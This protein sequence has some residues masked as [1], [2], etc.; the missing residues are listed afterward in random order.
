LVDRLPKMPEDIL[1]KATVVEK[2]FNQINGGD[3]VDAAAEAE[4][5]LTDALEALRI[6][7]TYDMVDAPSEDEARDKAIAVLRRAGVKGDLG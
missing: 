7:L 4:E 5:L 3:D 2:L 1:R 6:M